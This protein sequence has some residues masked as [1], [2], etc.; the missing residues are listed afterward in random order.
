MICKH[1]YCADCSEKRFCSDQRRGQNALFFSP[2]HE[3]MRWGRFDLEKNEP[4]PFSPA[5]LYIPRTADARHP[6]NCAMICKHTYCADCSEKRFCSDQRR[7]QNALSS[8]YCTRKCA[9]GVST[10]RKMN[11]TLFH[12]LTTARENALGGVSTL[13]K[14]NLT[15][16]HCTRKCAV[17]GKGDVAN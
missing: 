1:T 14:M 2:L 15:L 8:H 9:G 13:R 4:D 10:L 5:A 7:G 12:F 6:R 11:L 16:F 17:F 3:K